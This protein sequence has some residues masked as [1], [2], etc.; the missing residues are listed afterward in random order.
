MLPLGYV[1][2]IGKPDSDIIANNTQESQD[3]NFTI[4]TSCPTEPTRPSYED[5]KT[6]AELPVSKIAF[7]DLG[8]P[9][10]TMWADRNIGANNESDYGDLYSWGETSTKKDYRESYYTNIG[11]NNIIGTQYDVATQVCGHDYQMPT[12][13]QFDELIKECRWEWDG[14]GYIVIGKNGKSISLPATGWSCS[15]SIEHRDV[16]GYYWTGN[17]YN[18]D[19]AKGLLFSKSEKKTGNGYLYYG[20]AVRPVK[21]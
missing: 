8:L 13:K 14:N 18:S 1:N 11:T 21:R 10:K 4:D 16:Y 17:R 15:S 19:F 9:S 7:V 6:T 3:E 5:G 2:Y 20:R 12:Q